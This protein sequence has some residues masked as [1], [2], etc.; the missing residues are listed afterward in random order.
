MR[1]DLNSFPWY[2]RMHQ[3]IRLP[4]LPESMPCWTQPWI[5]T[6]RGEVCFQLSKFSSHP[7]AL[8][9]VILVFSPHRQ[10]LDHQAHC[11]WT[12]GLEN[13]LWVILWLAVHIL[14]CI[15]HQTVFRL[16]H[17]VHFHNLDHSL[18]R[19]FLL[20]ILNPVL[21]PWGIHTVALCSP[22]ISQDRLGFLLQHFRQLRYHQWVA[23]LLIL[24]G[25]VLIL[26]L[27]CGMIL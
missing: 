24:V 7:V 27:E 9:S 4:S 21:V 8:S 11:L 5:P 18:S 13:I 15:L 16:P 22:V 1:C 10:T 23:C 26:C 14:E 17:L 19:L 12:K 20:W 6:L 3:R 25:L 2:C